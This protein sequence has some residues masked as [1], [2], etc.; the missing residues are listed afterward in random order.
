MKRTVGLL[1][2]IVFMLVFNEKTSALTFKTE[3]SFVV[4]TPVLVTCELIEGD[5]YVLIIGH[6]G[7]YSNHRGYKTQDYKYS[8]SG[9]LML[10]ENRVSFSFPV[11]IENT[12]I[13]A[14]KEVIITEDNLSFI[15]KSSTGGT[16]TVRS[17]SVNNS[18]SETNIKC[19]I[20]RKLKIVLKKVNNM[21]VE[22]VENEVPNIKAGSKLDFEIF[23]N[24][25]EESVLKIEAEKEGNGVYSTR[26]VGNKIEE[27]TGN[28][29][30]KNEITIPAGAEN[31]DVSLV[32]PYLIYK[33]KN[34]NTEEFENY[35]KENLL[36]RE[37]D[38]FE[39]NFVLNIRFILSTGVEECFPIRILR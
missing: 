1:F 25:R 24:D 9:K 21:P 39:K 29:F 18:I 3:K 34:D 38:F 10:K 23:Y 32:V 11:T 8:M 26:V 22:Y 30:D 35:G 4:D 36:D 31:T 37:E 33:I 6:Y 13:P 2:F 5:P 17:V 20:K 15:P 14:G 27:F 7:N 16:I 19:E 28:T 12:D